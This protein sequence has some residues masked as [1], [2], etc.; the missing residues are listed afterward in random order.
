MNAIDMSDLALEE[1]SSGDHQNKIYQLLWVQHYILGESRFY[2]H[3]KPLIK[4]DRYFVAKL[5]PEQLNLYTIGAFYR[6]GYL[7]EDPQAIGEVL[8]ISIESKERNPIVR[9]KELIPHDFYDLRA[10]TPINFSWDQRCVVVEEKNQQVIIPC[11]ILGATYY[12]RSA[13][14]RQHL[15][16]R[17]LE[18]LY[19]P[20]SIKV[21]DRKAEI[22]LTNF[23][24]D[25]DAAEIIRF[26]KDPI[27]RKHWNEL[28]DRLRVTA[29]HNSEHKSNHLPIIADFPVAQRITIRARVIIKTDPSTGRE[30]ILV[31]DIIDEDSAYAFDMVTIIRDGK[32]KKSLNVT[33]RAKSY[34]TDR[35]LRP[36]TP[37]NA[38]KTII[39]LN[40]QLPGNP[41]KKQMT[42][43]KEYLPQTS[44]DT[45]IEGARTEQTKAFVGISLDAAAECGDPGNR[46]GETVSDES[47][48]ENPLDKDCPLLMSFSAL[49][50]PLEHEPEI[51]EFSFYG[52]YPMPVRNT[53]GARG[54]LRE[55]YDKEHM[56]RR[57]Y[58]QV[59]FFYHMTSV[60][61]C[62]IEIDQNGLK[63]GVS[64]CI[65]ISS[66]P[67]QEWTDLIQEYLNLFVKNTVIENIEK[68]FKKIGIS[69]LGKKHPHDVSNES[70][71]AWCKALLSRI[72]NLDNTQDS[73]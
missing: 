40:K 61:V 17:N 30:R 21:R 48:K 53:K 45:N 27:A 49:V 15:F 37:T 67:D 73:D 22:H 32:K 16:E 46:H 54:S 55:Y 69:Y 33:R 25:N 9:I 3:F 5:K 13:S 50:E 31:L 24:R 19:S 12:F 52:G 11:C 70:A 43:K 23:A 1:M 14:M 42:I 20:G 71:K 4:E 38:L 28:T 66:S 39:I 34:R 65:L 6:N 57:R 26:A 64:T 56:K 58:S 44:T 35:K 41:N 72:E 8:T 2:V 59:T 7:L 36:T 68:H 10:P 47:P 51:S 60:S 63:S 18:A 29:I 62:L